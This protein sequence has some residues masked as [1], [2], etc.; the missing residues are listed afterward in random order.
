MPSNA[1]TGRSEIGS[2]WKR[3]LWVPVVAVVTYYAWRYP[4]HFLSIEKKPQSQEEVIPATS[5]R[6]LDD[7]LSTSIVPPSSIQEIRIAFSADEK[8]QWLA[9]LDAKEPFLRKAAI[10]MWGLD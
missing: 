9:Y 6:Q 5:A 7:S 3:L 1:L 10:I 2:P 4:E 8:Q